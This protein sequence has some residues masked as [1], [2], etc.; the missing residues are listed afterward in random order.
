M[1]TI[2]Q[3]SHAPRD[4]P[5]EIYHYCS[6]A[7]FFG[8]VSSRSIWLSNS[9]D[10]NDLSEMKYLKGQ[11]TGFVRRLGRWLSVPQN[12][13][14]Y[15]T[16]AQFFDEVTPYSAQ[17]Q[18][19]LLFLQEKLGTSIV[20]N[21]LEAVIAQIE[22]PVYYEDVPFIACFSSEK[23]LLSQWVKYAHSG[24][25]ICIGFDTG[26]L[27]QLLDK[28]NAAYSIG[29]LELPPFSLNPICYD[30]AQCAAYVQ[31]EF[32]EFMQNVFL[33]TDE[34]LNA[35]NISCLPP[36]M[37]NGPLQAQL[38]AYVDDFSI[39]VLR[40]AGLFKHYGFAEEAEYRL[41][42]TDP[43]LFDQHFL[44]QRTLPI[45]CHYINDKIR[46]HITLDLKDL[47]EEGLITSVTIGPAYKGST[48]DLEYF[49]RTRLSEKTRIYYS[50]IPFRLS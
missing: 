14:V 4:C 49:I 10:M 24:T 26:K 30:P 42:T 21:I 16:Y 48:V 18:S 39:L 12:S 6:V 7:S 41:M 15:Q 36:E 20:H 45:E 13:A 38:K 43:L 3:T 5:P 9:M 28:T 23:D 46:T 27:M 11:V 2:Q 8:I 17:I 47:W 33:W 37:M 31:K 34:V 50:S 19:Q 29:S 25:G 35:R 22:Q 40:K 44:Q 1:E 32:A